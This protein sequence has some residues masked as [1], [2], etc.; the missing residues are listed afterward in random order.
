MR[1][2]C[3]ASAAQYGTPGRLAQHPCVSNAAL[4][5]TGLN[6]YILIAAAVC[7]LAAGVILQIQAN[8]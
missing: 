1:S 4:P 8:R 3:S 6:L 5:W 2:T 7:L